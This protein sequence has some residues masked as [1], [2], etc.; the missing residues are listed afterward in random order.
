MGDDRY[1]CSYT[2]VTATKHTVAV[3]WGGVCVPNSPFR[4]S[5]L[6]GEKWDSPIDVWLARDSEQALISQSEFQFSMGLALVNRVSGDLLPSLNF[7]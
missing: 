6:N 2:P 3:A 5:R 1:A 7:W 4:V